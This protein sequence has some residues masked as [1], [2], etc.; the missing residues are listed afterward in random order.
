LS[1]VWDVGDYN[2][3]REAKIAGKRAH[4]IA[5]RADGEIHPDAAHSTAI[6]RA[7]KAAPKRKKR[8]EM[9]GGAVRARLDRG[10]RG[11]MIRDHDPKGNGDQNL[12]EREGSRETR[13]GR[14]VARARGGQVVRRSGRDYSELAPEHHERGGRAKKGHTTVNVVVA[15]HPG[16]QPMPVPVPAG[17]AP[18]M[19]AQA[20]PP[21]P[22]QSMMASQMMPPQMMAPGT[23][24]PIRHAGGRVMRASGGSIKS[25]PAWKEGLRNMTQI[26]HQPGKNDLK[27]IGRGPAVTRRRGG[28]V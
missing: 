9:A 23:P 22:V 3:Y 14:T 16:A 6:K 2:D 5:R 12:L 18:P 20:R 4:R 10:A 15:P 25:G 19:A 24:L 1:E 11:G 8:L 27:D 28:S 21:M 7:V 17:V 26:S 13:M